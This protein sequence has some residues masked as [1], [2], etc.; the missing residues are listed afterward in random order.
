MTTTLK[1]STIYVS[2]YVRYA[3]SRPGCHGYGRYGTATGMRFCGDCW[4]RYMLVEYCQRLCIDD[5]STRIKGGTYQGSDLW[6]CV[7]WICQASDEEI[8]Q[9]ATALGLEDVA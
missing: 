6:R 3:C 8:E 5:L 9:W 2:P 4:R 7:Q 1:R